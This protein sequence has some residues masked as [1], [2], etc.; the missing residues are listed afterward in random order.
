MSIENSSVESNKN[1]G[2]QVQEILVGCTNI[3]WYRD[4][5][6]KIYDCFL[7]LSKSNLNETKLKSLGLM[8]LAEEI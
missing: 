1:Y 4:N 3:S 2:N 8:F 7:S 6:D 5:F